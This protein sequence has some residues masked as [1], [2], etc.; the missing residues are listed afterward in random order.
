MSAQFFEA[1]LK[2]RPEISP[3][4][5]KGNFSTL[6]NWLIGNIYQYGRKYTAAEL[7]ER[8][9]GSPLSI[10]PFIRYIQQKSGE[11]YAL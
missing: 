6:H 3:Q 10:E 2:A 4:M 9:T 7:I 11:L 5:E 1:A 8:V